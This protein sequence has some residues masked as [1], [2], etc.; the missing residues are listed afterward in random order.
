MIWTK[1]SRKKILKHFTFCSISFSP[2]HFHVT[3]WNFGSPSGQCNSK[4]L[5]ILGIFNLEV[6]ISQTDNAVRFNCGFYGPLWE[7][8][9]LCFSPTLFFP[10]FI[11]GIYFFAPKSGNV[12]GLIAGISCK[13]LATGPLP[14][15]SCSPDSEGGEEQ[16][17]LHSRSQAD[18]W[19]WHCSG[20][21]PGVFQC[22]LWTVCAKGSLPPV[23]VS[24]QRPCRAWMP[25]T[26]CALTQG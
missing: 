13:G 5:S 22:S 23:S 6:K 11:D 2:L 14:Q 16:A 21:K 26:G 8:L 1:V 10:L 17:G 19:A 18:A 12:H 25:Y 9:V 20:I 15:Y 3:T 24:D 4:K 7:I